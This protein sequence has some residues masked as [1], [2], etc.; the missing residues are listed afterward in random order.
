MTMAVTTPKI[1]RKTKKD[2]GTAII[3]MHAVNSRRANSEFPKA[4]L[5]RYTK[6]LNSGG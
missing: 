6:P 4:K 1:F 5:Q 2:M 3:P